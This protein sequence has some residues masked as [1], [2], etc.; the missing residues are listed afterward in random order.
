LESAIHDKNVKNIRAKIIVEGANGP[1]TPQA[2]EELIKKNILV[3]PDI[4]ANGGGAA[5]SYF[6]WVQDISWLFWTEQEVREKLK[7]IMV[8]AFTRVWNF[9]KKYQ[10]SSEKDNLRLS[11]MAIALLRLEK[12][13]KLRGQV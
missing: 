10:S 3:V 2:S 9:T 7:S 8:N 4:L 13:M 12:A 5:V 6:E 1:V 11:A